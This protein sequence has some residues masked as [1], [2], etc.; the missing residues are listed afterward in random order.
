MFDFFKKT[1][2]ILTIE[3]LAVVILSSLNKNEY[4][5]L[6]LDENK[7]PSLKDRLENIIYNSRND[8]KAEELINSAKGEYSNKIDEAIKNII[9]KG[10]ILS[11]NY[12]SGF[13]TND[14]LYLRA[15]E[16]RSKMPNS[17]YNTL[18]DKGDKLRR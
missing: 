16:A 13:M 15:E 5:E 4:I 6:Y 9:N 2:G 12:K 17:L 8:S 18:I 10:Y 14:S 11:C 3:D 1:R 7:S